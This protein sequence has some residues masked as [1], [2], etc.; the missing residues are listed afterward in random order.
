MGISFVGS[1]LASSRTD[2]MIATRQVVRAAEHLAE[3]AELDQESV[4]PEAAVVVVLIR[5]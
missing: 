4:S 3:V 5:R 2:L 1:Y